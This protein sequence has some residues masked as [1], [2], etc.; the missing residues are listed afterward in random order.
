ML[1][2][3]FNFIDLNKPKIGISELLKFEDNYKVF[4]PE[5]LK[6]LFLEMNHCILEYPIVDCEGID[7]GVMP[8]GWLCIGENGMNG[9][10]DLFGE[11]LGKNVIPFCTDPG[12]N[13]FIVAMDG[14]RQTGVY[15]VNLDEPYMDEELRRYK[16]YWLANNLADFAA[17]IKPFTSTQIHRNPS[18]L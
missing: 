3:M 12:S 2:K 9:M 16:S 5:E 15:Y 4:V 6:E 17:K 18:I 7:G 11:S 14:T 8:E 10:L 1:L 13:I